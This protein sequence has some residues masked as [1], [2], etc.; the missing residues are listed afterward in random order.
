MPRNGSL[1][2]ALLTAVLG[3]FVEMWGANILPAVGELTLAGLLVTIMI[4]KRDFEALR[5]G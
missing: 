2:F 3:T 5:K 4:V 1:G